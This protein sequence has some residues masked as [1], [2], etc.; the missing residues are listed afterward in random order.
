MGLVNQLRRYWP[1]GLAA[2]ALR[3]PGDLVLLGR[4]AWRF[5]RNAWWRTAPFLPLPDPRY[6]EFRRVTAFGT[7]GEL[8]VESALAAARWSLSQPRGH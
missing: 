4:V 6:W 1:R 7:E 2:R 8:D 3:R 5:R